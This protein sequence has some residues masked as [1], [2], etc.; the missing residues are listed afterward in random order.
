MRPN[1]YDS[2]PAF[3]P[4]KAVHFSG[5]PT[6][7]IMRVCK[8][9]ICRSTRPQAFSCPALS[10]CCHRPQQHCKVLAK[11]LVWDSNRDGQRSISTPRELARPACGMCCMLCFKASQ[12]RHM[13]RKRSHFSCTARGD[14]LLRLSNCFLKEHIQRVPATLCPVKANAFT[15]CETRC[16]T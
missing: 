2:W 6:A 3:P 1:T 4:R 14:A 13:S 16:T 9:D 7:D 15:S 11:S 12:A 5:P 8:F 10:R